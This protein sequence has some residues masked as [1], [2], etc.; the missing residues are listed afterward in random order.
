MLVTSWIWRSTTLSHSFMVQ[1]INYPIIPTVLYI[2]IVSSF[3][4]LNSANLKMH[5]EAVLL[6][7]ICS[8]TYPTYTASYT[9]KTLWL[10][11][12]SFKKLTSS[13]LLYM[14]WST[15]ECADV[16]LKMQILEEICSSSFSKLRVNISF[17]V[18]VFLSTPIWTPLVVVTPWRC[19]RMG[20]LKV[21]SLNQKL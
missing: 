18:K 6:L 20:G 1:H 15:K 12:T 3:N 8:L 21:K 10:L 16:D 4:F 13:Q 9:G 7:S 17:E 5:W 2:K 19:T 14:I 11:K